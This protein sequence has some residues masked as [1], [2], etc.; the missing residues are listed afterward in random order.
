MYWIT[1]TSICIL[2]H[3]VIHT[4]V[5]IHAIAV[6]RD[7]AFTEE[8]VRRGAFGAGIRRVVARW[9]VRPY[10]YYVH[11]TSA[12]YMQKFTLNTV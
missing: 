8:A 7:T 6:Y 10:V 4:Y 12:E 9:Y 1:S 3:Y 5:P 11:Y 2:L